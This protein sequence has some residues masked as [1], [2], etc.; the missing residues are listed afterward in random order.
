M[1]HERNC[2]HVTQTRQ[3]PNQRDHKKTHSRKN[4]ISTLSRFCHLLLL[5]QRP[6]HRADIVCGRLELG[7]FF[8]GT[9]ESFYFEGGGGGVGEE[10]GEDCA[11]Y[12]AWG[13]SVF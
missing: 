8:R 13:E 10:A 11:T 2:S 4:D 9:D 3:K 12:V 1:I 5:A 6:H 7:G